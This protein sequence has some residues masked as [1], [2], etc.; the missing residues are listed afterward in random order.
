L[1]SHQSHLIID[2][3]LELPK[4]RKV[5]VK[6]SLLLQEK[7]SYDNWN[8]GLTESEILLMEYDPDNV[9]E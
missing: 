3:V 1:A 2:D 9:E 4:L 8:T 6:K 7:L 5:F